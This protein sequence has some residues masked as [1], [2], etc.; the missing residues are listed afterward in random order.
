MKSDEIEHVNGK[1][2][3][4]LVGK[5]P[6]LVVFFYDGDCDDDDDNCAAILEKLEELDDQL[7]IYGIDMVK[8]NLIHSKTY[9][10]KIL[11]I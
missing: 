7:D 2:L 1:M 5:S 10:L 3:E 8:G 4:K 6:F 11:I 9:W